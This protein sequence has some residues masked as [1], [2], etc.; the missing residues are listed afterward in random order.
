MGQAKLRG[1]YETRKAEG[2]ARRECEEQQRINELAA[3]EAALTNAQ[4]ASRERARQILVV[5]AGIAAADPY[6]LGVMRATRMLQR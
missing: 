1:S 5:G 4:R 3:Q 2:E 6:T